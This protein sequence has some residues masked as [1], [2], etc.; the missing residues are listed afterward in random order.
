MIDGGLGSGGDADQ[1]Q[2]DRVY[3][4]TKQNYIKKIINEFAFGGTFPLIKVGSFI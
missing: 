2:L 4:R 1:K 3:T